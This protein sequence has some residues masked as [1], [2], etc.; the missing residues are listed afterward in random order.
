LKCWRR[1]RFIVVGL[2]PEGSSG[3]L[4]LREGIIFVIAPHLKS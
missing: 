3:I 4:K 1:D 2:A